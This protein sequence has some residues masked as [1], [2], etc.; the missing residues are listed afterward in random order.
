[1]RKTRSYESLKVMLI[2]NLL[3]LPQYA[4]KISKRNGHMYC[5]DPSL[6]LDADVVEVQKVARDFAR[7][8][9]Y[10][11]MAKWDK[12]EYFPVEMMRHAGE[13]GF[14]AIYCKEDYGGCGMTRLHASVIFEQLAAG[15]VSTAAYMSIHNMCA[16]MIDTYGPKEMREKY[17]PSMAAFET[18]SSYCLTEP[19]SGSDAASLSTIAR[20]E[21]DYYVVNGSKAFISGA[22]SS[23]IYVVMVRHEGQ[24]GAKGIFCLLIEDGMEGFTQ[25]KKEQ[26]LGWNTQPTRI[27]SFEDVKV[28][29]TNQIGPDNHGFNIA[30]AGLNGGRINIASCS[31]GAAQQSIDLAIDQLKVRKQFGKPLSEFQWNQF[32]LAEIATKLQSSRLMIRDAARHLDADSIHKAA[33]CAMAKLHA[34][35]NCSQIVNQ[36][37]QMFGGYGYLKDYPLQQYLRD[38]RV[39]EILEGTNEMMRLIIGRDLLMNEHIAMS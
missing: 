13:L 38:L 32:K 12:E 30:M 28:P 10:P 34:T 3:R 11:N 14:G 19:N 33:L 4:S 17:I 39:H 20:R 36:A 29:V 18:L 6:G 2:R 21:G 31:L 26:K 27:L 22:G 15:C 9:M 37:L 35:E 7:K 1:M 25:G 23:K 8:E 16:W 5:V 24:S